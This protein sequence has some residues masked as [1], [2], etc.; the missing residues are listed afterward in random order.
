MWFG[1]HWQGKGMRGRGRVP[2]LID[3][4]HVLLFLGILNRPMIQFRLP[5]G[6]ISLFFFFIW[7]IFPSRGLPAREGA[8]TGR[9][10]KLGLRTETWGWDVGSGGTE[11]KKYPMIWVADWPPY[12]HW[13]QKP[14][15]RA[16]GWIGRWLW[17]MMPGHAWAEGLL[18]CKSQLLV[19]RDATRLGNRPWGLA[20]FSP[21]GWS[22][23]LL[24]SVL[25]LL[26]VVLFEIR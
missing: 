4:H 16:E 26:L 1:L 20:W 25:V 18:W 13:T 8:H 3:G 12:V 6:R 22:L 9:E 19:G 7:S 14:G 10:R 2:K 5:I 23:G 11:E 21:R 24:G 15:G 17:G